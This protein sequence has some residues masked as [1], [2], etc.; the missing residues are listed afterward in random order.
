MEQL[1]IRHCAIGKPSIENPREEH[2]NIDRSSL[3]NGV[4]SLAYE[5]CSTVERSN[6]CT[7]AGRTVTSARCDSEGATYEPARRREG[8]FV[9]VL[10]GEPR[11]DG[12]RCA[13]HDHKRP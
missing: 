7:R 4:P 2:L 3:R 11:H 8:R 5:W 12:I 13:L 6:K 1:K 9:L 10:V